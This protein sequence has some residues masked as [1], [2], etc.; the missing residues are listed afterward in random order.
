M[1]KIT[2]ANRCLTPL[3]SVAAI[4]NCIKCHLFALVEL[5]EGFVLF[6]KHEENMI[7]VCEIANVLRAIGQT[8]TESEAEQLIADSVQTGQCHQLTPRNS[9]LKENNFK[10]K[11]L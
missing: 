9:S 6:D 8:P 2:C 10:V 4:D 7:P 5:K 3:V 11:R 1:S